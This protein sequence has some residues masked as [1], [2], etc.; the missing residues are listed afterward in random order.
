MPKDGAPTAIA[1]AF[2]LVENQGDAWGIIVEA[3][4]RHVQQVR[5]ALHRS[6]ALTRA[7]D[8]R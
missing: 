4:S 3:L 1:A 5:A 8:I 2:E 6:L 7:R